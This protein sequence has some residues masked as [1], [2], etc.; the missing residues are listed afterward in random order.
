MRPSTSATASTS[1]RWRPL[2]RSVE[3][4]IGCSGSLPQA[5]NL[6]TA[7]WPNTAPTMTIEL[8]DAPANQPGALL[9]SSGCQPPVDLSMIG[10][11]GCRLELLAPGSAGIATG[12]SGGFTFTYTAPTPVPFAGAPIQFQAAVVAPGANPLG[13]LASNAV[14]VVFQ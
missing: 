2:T 1:S 3:Y 10:M 12:P 4:G 7:G 13:I 8:S 11:P 14:N 6:H 5:P 9:F